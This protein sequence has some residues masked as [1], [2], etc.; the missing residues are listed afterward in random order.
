MCSHPI[1]VGFTL[2]WVGAH[3]PE[4]K[5]KLCLSC[6]E[7]D[8]I[9]FIQASVMTKALVKPLGWACPCG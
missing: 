1:A 4:E 9:T 3:A 2:G 7:L 5:K 8:H 6:M